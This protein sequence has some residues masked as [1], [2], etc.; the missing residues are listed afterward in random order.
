MRCLVKCCAMFGLGHYI[1]A[2]ESVPQAQEEPVVSV[3]NAKIVEFHTFV[4]K[5]NDPLGFLCFAKTI[6]DEA[7]I[8]LHKT[9]EPGKIVANKKIVNTLITRSEAII[10]DAVN[11]VQMHINNN[12]SS[13]LLE[14][15]EEFS[16]PMARKLLGARLDAGQIKALQDV[17]RLGGAA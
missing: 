1:Y 15:I 9:F 4:A 3:D 14:I 13:G 2:G 16:N 10:D 7:L 6:G 5:N 11:Q 8:S 17:Q 12:D